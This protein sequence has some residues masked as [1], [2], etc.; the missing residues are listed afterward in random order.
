MKQS[1]LYAHSEGEINFLVS[2][3]GIKVFLGI[4]IMSGFC[5]V[6]SRRLYWENDRVCQNT[7]VYDVVRRNRYNNTVQYVHFA[8]N[9]V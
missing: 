3:N 9:F 8:D 7:A 5:P 1:V 6:L 4:L 2:Q